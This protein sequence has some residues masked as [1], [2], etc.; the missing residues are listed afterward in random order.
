[1]MSDNH[2]TAIVARNRQAMIGRG[3]M[4]PRQY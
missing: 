3:G 1:M 2:A 4:T